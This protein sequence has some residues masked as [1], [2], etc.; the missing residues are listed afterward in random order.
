MI[1][2]WQES[3]KSRLLAAALAAVLLTGCANPSA[4]QET[5]LPSAPTATAAPTEPTEA[6]DPGLYVPDSPVERS[7]DGAVKLYQFDGSVTGIGVLGENLLLC[8]GGDTLRLYETAGMTEIKARPLDAPLSWAEGSLVL[9]E[10]GLAW[11]DEAQEAY[12]VLDSSLVNTATVAI[13]SELACAPIISRDF[14]T[15]YFAD[16]EGIKAMNLTSG[17]SRM[18]RQDQGQI[19]QME[20]LLLGDS[21]LRYTRET[22]DGSRQSCF[23]STADGAALH[24]GTFTGEL[25]TDADSLTGTM[26]LSHPMGSESWIL[27]HTGTGTELL[28]RAK[29]YDSALPLDGDRVLVQ[30][31]DQ[32][33]LHL[34]L[35][36]LESNTY[37]AVMLPQF[38][39]CFA[40]AC[41]SGSEVWLCDGVSGKFYRWDAALTPVDK[42]TDPLIPAAAAAEGLSQVLTDRA[43][44]LSEETGVKITLDPGTAAGES[45]YPAYQDG[46]F[47]L[48]MEALEEELSRVP[49]EFWSA[50]GNTTDSGRLHIVLVDDYDP[51]TGLGGDSS[52]FS[53]EGGE[54]VITLSISR[55]MDSLLYRELWNIMEIRIRNRSDKLGS[56]SRYNPDGFSYTEDPAQWE[57]GELE[58]SGYLVPGENW[59]ADSY[60]M[61]SGRHDRMEVFRCAAIEGNGDLYQSAHMQE[62][63]RFLCELIRSAYKLEDALVLPWEQYLISESE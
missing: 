42:V 31:V 22:G 2:I 13:A 10:A 37:S 21:I 15:I 59:F 29:G 32:M 19:L 17:A 50:V 40:Y 39:G 60:G 52:S 14:S 20:G 55:D 30:H 25:V 61:I 23:I 47:A 62:K 58:S 53:V 8:T 56:W 45:G 34:S 35:Y 33:G 18:L 6:A 27:R 41:V 63:L 46:L 11:F 24:S 9:T 38:T 48:A 5:T 28:T 3:N 7:T 12:V 44:A 36:S 54:A 1:T 4:P 57:S 16:P 43:E 26:T 51:A 49:G